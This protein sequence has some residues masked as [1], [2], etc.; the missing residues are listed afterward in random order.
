[1]KQITG[2]WC[3]IF[4]QKIDEKGMTVNELGRD[5]NVPKTTIHRI[6]NGGT[7]SL[8]NFG[9]ITKFLNIKL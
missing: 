5:A 3:D 8:K 9:L 2:N 1:M 4:A 6:M 7:I